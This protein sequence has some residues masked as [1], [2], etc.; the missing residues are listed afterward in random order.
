MNL[1]RSHKLVPIE[2]HEVVLFFA[3]SGKDL[4][5]DFWSIGKKPFQLNCDKDVAIQHYPTA[6]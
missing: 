6:L 3:Y 5:S 4:F 2:L 1:I